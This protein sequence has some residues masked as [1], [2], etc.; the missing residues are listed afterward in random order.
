[1]K[2]LLLS[3]YDADSH[4]SWA[5]SLQAAFKDFQWTVLTLPPRHFSWRIRGNSLSWAFSQRQLLEQPYD[6]LIAT[7]MVD[8]SA[9]RGFVPALSQLPTLVYFHENQFVYPASKLQRQ[10]V[11]PQILNLYTA[12]AADRVAFNSAY[13]R[14][15]FLAGAEQLLQK[16]PDFVPSGLVARLAARSDVLSVPLTRSSD[17]AAARNN[18][19]P[20]QVLWNHR[21]EYDK[22]PERLLAAVVRTMAAGVFIEWH[23]VGQQFRQIPAAFEQLKTWFDS[24]YPEALVHWGYIEDGAE[25]QQLLQRADVV[26]STAL[27]DFQ[28]LAVLE[29]VA[30]GCLPLLPKRLCYGEWFSDEYLY[31][32]FEQQPEQ[33]AT[34]VAEVLIALATSKEQGQ[35]PVAPCVARFSMKELKPAYRRLME[36]LITAGAGQPEA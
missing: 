27:H 16:L 20:L 30:A 31:A 3:A 32:S 1:M 36:Q 8:L 24:H 19:Q 33:E 6:L 17:T 34:A 5:Q 9:L 21:W 25:Y 29:A 12:L 28:G 4:K 18:Q 2:I 35:L 10:G 23:I 15:T 11:E 22:A 14:D 7:S 13:N 26:L